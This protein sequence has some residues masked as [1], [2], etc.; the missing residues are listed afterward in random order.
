MGSRLVTA[1]DLAQR[2]KLPS[3]EA[4]VRKMSVDGARRGGYAPW[5]GRSVSGAPVLAFV[6]FGRWVAKCECGGL[7]YVDP[8]TPIYFCVRCGNGGTGCARPVQFPAN[9]DEIEEMILMIDVVEQGGGNA[10][11]RARLARPV[12]LSRPR[13]WYPGQGGV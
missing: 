10:I 12:D 9:L 3:V 5:N 7:G 4:L 2:D 6:D 1:F 13:N 8:D 11:E